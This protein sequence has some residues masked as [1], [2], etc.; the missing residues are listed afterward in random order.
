MGGVERFDGLGPVDAAVRLTPSVDLTTARLSAVEGF[1]LS[2]V[3]GTATLKTLCLVTGLG[4]ATTLEILRGLRQKGL[5]LVG[6]E[7]PPAQPGAGGLDDE[8]TD[9]HPMVTEEEP[10]APET[11]VDLSPELQRQV[12]ELFNKLGRLNIF[13]L[14]GVPPVAEIRE[15]RRAFF[16]QSK[17][18]HPDR[19]FGKRLGPFRDMLEEI[20]KQMNGGY[21]MLCRQEKLTE[22]RAMV[23]QQAE[24]ERLARQVEVETA[25]AM[26]EDQQ[27]ASQ[28]AESL[29]QAR[30]RSSSGTFRAHRAKALK[31]LVKRHRPDEP[32]SPA[33]SRGEAELA[34]ELEE[35]GQRR[36]DEDRKRRP[37]R[38]TGALF[39]RV[40]K[41][42]QFY[43]QAKQQLERGQYLAAAASLKLAVSFNPEE[44]EYRQAYERASSKARELTA[45]THFK[46]GMMEESVGRFDAAAESFVQAAQQEPTKAVYLQKAAEA[47]LWSGHLIKAKDYATRAV[48]VD[49]GSV[50][51]RIVAAKVFKAAGLKLN[52][53]RELQEALKIEPGNVEVKELLR[54][55]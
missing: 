49:P 7:R 1:V 43:A 8:D 24:E 44:P 18:Y 42:Q 27:A 16:A 39:T 48:Q 12:R 21:K 19:Y 11:E 9:E 50:D 40:K 55:L 35:E 13:E 46:R 31:E 38:V 10:Q 32:A 37:S 41:A 36:R 22:Y 30:P 45:E 14:L 26:E 28:L 6:D 5:I 53:R 51:I 33:G 29:G 47:S 34:A 15:I 3:D 23:L 17:I 20:F 4:E 52:A 2:R 25:E 54:G